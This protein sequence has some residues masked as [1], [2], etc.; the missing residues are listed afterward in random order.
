MKLSIPR[1][2]IVTLALLT[3]GEASSIQTPAL[4]SPAGET[5]IAT[6]SIHKSGL[7]GA[8]RS[9]VDLAGGRFDTSS[10]FGAYRIADIYDGR[11]RWRVDPS[12]AHHPLDS[13]FARATSRTEAWLAKFGWIQP[14]RGDATFSASVS[15]DE[16]GRRYRVRT[17]TPAGGRPVVLW[18]DASTGDL[19]RSEY[20]GWISSIVAHY[21]DYRPVSGRRLPFSIVSADGGDE[22]SIK[23]ANYAFEGRRSDA[24]FAPPPQ[25]DDADVPA[26]GTTVPAPYVPQLVVEASINGSAPMGFVFDTGGHNILT[27]AAAKALGLT[28]VGDS[29]SGGSGSSTIQ[30]RD[31]RVKTVRIG[32]ASV[33]DQHFYVLSL[34]YASME[35]GAKP[36]L[37]GILGLEILERFTVRVNYRAGTLTLLPRNTALTCRGKWQNITFTDDMSTVKGAL[38]GIPAAFTIDTGNNGS[39]MLYDYWARQ[40]KVAD[41]YRQGVETVSFG[42]GGASHNWVSHAR[43]VRL[44]D[45]R[46]PR[47]RVRTSD[48]TGG[49][50]LSLA[51]AGN[52]GTELL[53]NYTLTF[54]Y[55]RSRVC[56][57]YVPGYRLDAFNRSGMRATKMD[58][59]TFTVRMVNAGSPAELAGLRKDDRIVAIDGQPA[60]RLGGGDLARILTR[61]PGTKVLLEYLRDGKSSHA[62][63]VLREMLK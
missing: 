42:A 41:R 25:P 27:P 35:Q 53:A 8:W 56:F 15:K 50:A 62:Q 16:E 63:I 13:D 29:K 17:A 12:G 22:E 47:P 52:L 10:D 39:L 51:E 37:A 57:D 19:A 45:V 34:D 3:G 4:S 11:T 14:R 31:T 48:D 36:P 9:A 20:R 46:I 18:F 38:D 23:I 26:A 7:D 54:D 1:R 61:P 32:E 55:A 59:D 33:H 2:T 24:R 21:S 49:V 30:Q 28:A 40:H 58:P 6:G 60:Q 43:D 44:G 5:L